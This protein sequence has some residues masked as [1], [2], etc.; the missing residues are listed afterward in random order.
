MK[1]RI[2]G[3]IAATFFVILV[4]IAIMITFSNQP[5]INYGGTQYN[6]S[7]VLPE[8]EATE[9]AGTILTP[10][11]QQL[12][13]AIKGT[14]YIDKDNYTLRVY[15][16]VYNEINMTYKELLNLP[17]YS[18]VSYM[19]CVEGWGFT[20]KWTGFHVIDLLN[21]SGLKPDAAYVIFYSSDGYSTGLSLSYITEKNILM[22]Y[23]INDITLPPERG[24][25]FQVVADQKY[26]Y[27]WAK[28]ITGIEIVNTEK[29]G[30]WE[31]R[32]YNDTADVRT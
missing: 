28:W 27:K 22:A 7:N 2:I 17:A 6:A 9:F 26:G 18:E 10:L 14:Q 1:Y 8:V 15:G 32:G 25:P 4:I 11:S 19:P 3:Y 29:L 20:A 12:N 5:A 23:G 21:I 13:N 24:F 30:Y 16:L 31:S